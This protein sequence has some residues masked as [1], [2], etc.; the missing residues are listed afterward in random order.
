MKAILAGMIYPVCS[1]PIENG[2]ILV[3]NGRIAAVGK[4]LPIPEGAEILHMEDCTVTPGLIDAHTYIALNFEPRGM[5]EHSDLDECCDPITPD[6]RALD[7]FYPDDFAIRTARNAGFTTC[8]VSPGKKNIL[9]GQGAAFKM[10][11]CND[12]GKMIL[13]E[14]AQMNASI[15]EI[16]VKFHSGKTGAPQTRMGLYS[17]LRD[18][19]RKAAEYAAAEAPA[20]DRKLEAMKPVME[21]RM[22]LH[23]CTYTAADMLLIMELLDGY[24]IR[25]CFVGAA[26]AHLIT[27]ALAERDVPCIMGGLLAYPFRNELWKLRYDTPAVLTKAG[28]STVCFTCD[29][30]DEIEF[31]RAQAGRCTALG[32]TREQVLEGLTAA[33]A[34]LLGAQDRIG[35]IAPGMDADLSFFNGDPLSC[36]SLCTGVLIDGV[37]IPGEEVPV[38]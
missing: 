6:V 35:A 15:G 23:I 38:K 14:T 13:P 27:E 37:Y 10:K 17:M 4:D 9:G 8:Y 33:P 36:F 5:R 34:R 19:L 1:A 12:A 21:G 3:E 31:L 32:M 22:P 16:P 28:L 24:G 26:E 18:F 29:E 2:V 11:P 25:Y 20:Y 30:T 7:G